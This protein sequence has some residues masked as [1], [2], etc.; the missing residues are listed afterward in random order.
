MASDLKKEER[1]VY[2]SFFHN[3]EYKPCGIIHFKRMKDAAG[4]IN[5]VA[6]FAYL[7]SYDGPPIDP[8]NLNYQK[9][10]TR[11]FPLR[12]SGDGS[13]LHKIFRDYL[14]GRWGMDVLTAEY[15]EIK[16]MNDFE[17]LGWLGSRTVG[18]MSFFV[19]QPKNEAPVE[20]L[21]R[22]EEVRR[23]SV[24][25][26]LRQLNKIGMRE[27]ESALTSHGG[28]RP[29]VSFRDARGHDFLVKFNVDM[30]AFNYAR[31]E[32]ALSLMSKEVGI[33]TV[34]TSA[35]RMP[36]GEDAL[37]VLRYDC[38]REGTKVHRMSMM[39]LALNK[40][41]RE[42]NQGDYRD[43]FD[44]VRATCCDQQGQTEELFRRMLFNIA[45][46]HT[47]DHLKNFEMIQVGDC[48]Q[49]APAYDVLPQYYPYPHVSS[50]FG[51]PRPKLTDEFV[52]K[53]A[54]AVGV[55]VEWALAQR[56]RTVEVVGNWKHYMQEAEVPEKDISL[57][58]KAFEYGLDKAP[59][60]GL[61][62]AAQNGAQVYSFEHRKKIP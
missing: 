16:T 36:N 13:Y 19:V 29:K 21:Q 7:N 47:D 26:Y 6:G 50:F 31:M 35:V 49:L 24:D 5:E 53:A 33:D 14:P 45:T 12:P 3:G 54:E 30:D 48:C 51:E 52:T 20:G 38:D 56:D 32:K 43:M 25:F 60:A 61:K 1:S 62:L 55:P 57:I 18:A 27:S 41:I 9:A 44:I 22:L 37:F 59:K 2:V 10:N 34:K 11:I 39:T 46:N 23:R 17:M 28:A 40:N 8:V 58:A 15:P 42:I 4:N